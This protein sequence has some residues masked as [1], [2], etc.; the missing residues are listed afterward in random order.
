MQA[1]IVTAVLIGATLL[2]VSERLRADLVA[3]LALAVLLLFRVIDPTEALS[4]F[5]NPATV[6]VAC[7]FVLSAGLQASGVIGYIG[8]ALL[9]H[10][11]SS[12]TS[13]LLLSGLVIAPFSA[14]INNTAAVAI[15]L[16]IVLRACQGR[17]VSPSH[18]MMPLSFFA[19]LGGT[20]TLIGTS[21]N[22]LVSSL[23]EQR[24]YRPFGMFEFSQIGVVML[25]I[26]GVYLLVVARHFI[27]ERIQAESLT[28]GFHL[29]RY[30]SEVMVTPDSSLIGMTM[31]EARLGERYDLE[32]LGHV[33]DKQM[34]G[35]PDGHD[36]LEAGD[37]LLVQAQ[38]S[39]LV[40]VSA[41]MGLSIRP[42]KRPGDADL[43]SGD[44][45][46]VEAVIAPNSDLE[47]RSLKSVDFRN[48]F[49][50][51]ALAIRRHGEDIR[52]KIGH[53]RLGVGDELLIRVPR[54]KLDRLRR[55][56]S[57]VI[58]QELELPMI[59]PVQAVIACA[60]VVGVVISATVGL[61]PIADAALIG[62]VAMVLTG[63]IP[64]RKVYESVDWKVIF[65]LA[66]LIPMGIALDTSGAAASAVGIVMDVAGSAGPRVVLSAFILLAALLTGVMSNNATAALLAPL[67]ITFAG[68]LGVDPRPFLVGL[69]FAASAAF[70]TPIG[71]QTNL[72]VY[73]PG[74]Y[75]FLDFLRVGGP[76]T[77]LYWM[78][79]TLLV[80]YFFPF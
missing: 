71:Y 38:A 72:L 40:R 59:K 64:A 41:A 13:L 79:T 5:S 75:R 24:G 34:R 36:R 50:A 54:L 18:L 48:R 58:L 70:Y 56:S 45:A 37:I 68:E 77:L 29:N 32:V 2:L 53:V 44:A 33:R 62:A 73:G 17:N 43:R 12:E 23:A 69:T 51:T 57:F 7:M 60:I 30:L 46:L 67:A 1:V 22:I 74:G 49:G 11:P 9:R 28:E 20:C 61:Y 65:L 14:V 31:H 3:M 47:G 42:G 63:C 80:P 35:L 15:F 4:G 19:M 16:P 21:T 25:V 10:G 76:L 27:P 8:D 55:E 66:G 6:A 39:A 26:G 78:A 52:E